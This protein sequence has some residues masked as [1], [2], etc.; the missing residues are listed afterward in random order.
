MPLAVCKRMHAGA[1]SFRAW[2]LWDLPQ[3]LSAF[4][5]ITTAVYAAALGLAAAGA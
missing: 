5:V 3:G 2:P 1:R 4:I